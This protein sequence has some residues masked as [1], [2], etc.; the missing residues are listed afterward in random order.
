M[1]SG[2]ARRGQAFS[3]P[4]VVTPGV[5]GWQSGIRAADADLRLRYFPTLLRPVPMS[6]LSCRSLS[7][8]G[9]AMPQRQYRYF[10]F[11]MVAFVVVLVC[12]NLIG[13]A[14][15]GEVNLPFWGPYVFGVGVIF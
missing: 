14:K 5:E 12:S 4:R 15:I 13:P 10:E 9:G 11:V 8:L 3:W 6:R 2:P 1:S 7:S